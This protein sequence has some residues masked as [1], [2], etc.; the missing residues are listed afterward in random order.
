MKAIIDSV[1]NEISNRGLRT[2]QPNVIYSGHSF[3]TRIVKARL[4]TYVWKPIHIIAAMPPQER[5]IPL[6]QMMF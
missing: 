3:P 1:K 6:T 2:G 4:S 5:T